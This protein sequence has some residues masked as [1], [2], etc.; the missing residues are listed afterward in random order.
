MKKKPKKLLKR[1]CLQEWS[2]I[3]RDRDKTCQWCN[4]RHLLHSHHIVSRSICNLYGLFDPLN[5]VTLC[6]RCHIHRLKSEPQEYV[7][8]IEAWL[9]ER[10]LTYDYLRD[11]YRPIVK[12]SREDYSAK[13][14][15]LE[16]K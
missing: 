3:I 2:R 9:T 15:E 6:Y 11:L 13:L 14:K 16:R 8:F 7:K 5:G 1:L 4:S 10:D 12:L